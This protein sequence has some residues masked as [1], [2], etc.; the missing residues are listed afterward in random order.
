MVELDLAL[1]GHPEAGNL[2]ENH[3]FSRLRPQAWQDAPESPSV[4]KNKNDDS[5]FKCYVDEFEL[6]SLEDG[7]PK[8]WEA[9]GKVI[10]FSEP[11]GVRDY[12]SNGKEL[13]VDPEKKD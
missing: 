2:W 3:A 8:H 11:H 6:Q 10:D 7:T 4:F 12:R 1:F 5:I 13:V 9:I